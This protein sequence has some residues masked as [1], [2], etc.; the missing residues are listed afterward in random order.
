MYSVNNNIEREANMV[1]IQ[2]TSPVPENQNDSVKGAQVKT[3]DDP[4]NSV[5]S[6]YDT[7]KDGT[8]S[9]SEKSDAFD[10]SLGELK[11]VLKEKYEELKAK[12]LSGA[13][14][15]KINNEIDATMADLSVSLGLRKALGDAEKILTDMQEAN[16]EEYNQALSTLKNQY[17][18]YMLVGEV[19][20]ANELLIDLTPDEIKYI[21]GE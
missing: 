7:N 13:N 3:N 6:K 17:I 16:D 12:F 8:L 15:E 4:P 18:T 10:A 21:K 20:K 11:N 2:G 9:V 14:D 19:D 1:S 5:F